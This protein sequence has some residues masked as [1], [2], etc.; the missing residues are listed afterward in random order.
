[1]GYGVHWCHIPVK[2]LPPVAPYR[3]IITASFAVRRH[4]IARALS[5]PV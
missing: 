5:P 2:T 4:F 3:L 1:M